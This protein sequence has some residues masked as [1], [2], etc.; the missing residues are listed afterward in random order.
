MPDIAIDVEGA[1]SRMGSRDLYGAIVRTFVALMPETLAELN[2]AMTARN[3][4]EAR[5]LLHSLKS[6]CA[7]LGAEE[8]RA[9]A[10]AAE[11]ACA[12]A[13]EILA[14]TLYPPLLEELAALREAL[15]SLYP[16]DGAPPSRQGRRI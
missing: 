6:N 13:D 10:H 3:W 9:R 2:A 14:A 12:A 16:S 5:R 15:S 11:K 1:V 4:P 7:S 8:T